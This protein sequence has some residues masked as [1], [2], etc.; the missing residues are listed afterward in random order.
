LCAFLSFFRTTPANGAAPLSLA[1]W[2]AL[3][4]DSAKN[5]GVQKRSGRV[6]NVQRPWPESEKLSYAVSW[7]K[8]L[9][10]A[11]ITT[12]I[13]RTQEPGGGAAFQI[14]MM[15][16]TAGIVDAYIYKIRDLYETMADAQT[17]QP[18]RGTIETLHGKKTGNYSFSID[19]KKNALL[20]PDHQKIQIPPATYDIPTLFFM[21]RTIDLTPG[22]A[23][24]FNLVDKGKLYALRAEVEGREEVLIQKKKVMA[25]RIAIKM[26]NAKVP[27][28]STKIRCYLSDDPRR[29]PVLIS[30]EPKWG[31]VIMEL[32]SGGL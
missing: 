17:L 14:K 25:I 29:L 31:R 13:D 3:P 28:D 7:E 26:M 1:C 24:N 5:A 32:S 10:A 22:K 4:S 21:L 2:A 11:E 8:F 16:K 23:Q 12:S 6:P 27:D 30:A 9:V 19:R 18:F 15:A 20:L